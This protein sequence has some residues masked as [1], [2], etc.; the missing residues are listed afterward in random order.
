MENGRKRF[1]PYWLRR[2]EELLQ[3]NVLLILDRC[4]AIR[5]LANTNGDGDEADSEGARI[6]LKDALGEIYQRG[7]PEDNPLWAAV[8]MIRPQVIN[9]RLYTSVTE[10]VARALWALNKAEEKEP[11]KAEFFGKLAGRLRKH[12][13]NF[14]R[15]T[16][17][18]EP[19]TT[20]EKNGEW[21]AHYFP[22]IPFAVR[23]EVGV[24][25]STAPENV[26]AV[27]KAYKLMA[28]KTTGYAKTAL[29]AVIADIEILS[30]RLYTKK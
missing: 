19:L 27:V 30:E 7:T 26:G 10:E 11:I 17:H 28:E 20:K 9:G 21:H 14:F 24:R 4:N 29:D 18:G 5:R 3:Q 23:K 12:Q 13:I 8:M 25:L 16:I 2:C 15:A 6:D 1:V 22:G